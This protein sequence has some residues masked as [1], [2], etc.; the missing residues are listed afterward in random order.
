M[1]DVLGIVFSNLYMKDLIKCRLVNKLC[2]NVI[3]NNP[4]LYKLPVINWEYFD[5]DP[6]DSI[7]DCMPEFSW[8]IN[9][10]PPSK[11]ESKE[12]N[13]SELIGKYKGRRYMFLEEKIKEVYFYQNG[14]NEE[15]SWYLLG[16]LDSGYYFYMEA[17]CGYTGFSCC[18]SIEFVFSHH[19]I[20]LIKFGLDN[21]SRSSLFDINQDPNKETMDFGSKF[22]PLAATWYNEDRTNRLTENK[23]G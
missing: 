2:C 14:E 11:I 20:N 12:Y 21:K 17:S 18:G 10:T 23:G 7:E 8:V 3:D 9:E 22:E 1:K 19:L 4:E 16:K 6:L 13:I 15:S 5:R